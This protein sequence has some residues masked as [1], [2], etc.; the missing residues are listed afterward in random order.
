MTDLKKYQFKLPDTGVPATGALPGWG[1]RTS[2]A[3][4]HATVAPVSSELP[5]DAAGCLAKGNT[6]LQGGR[7]EDALRAY[8]RAIAL[9]PDYLEPH[10]NR[11]NVLLRL[12]RLPEA[13]AAFERA[14]A[15][16]P[17]LAIAHYNR[18]TILGT[19]GRADEALAG[20][21]RT[22][23]LDSTMVQAR[24][25]LGTLYLQKGDAEQALACLDQVIAQAP[26]VVQAHLARGNA[27]VKMKKLEQAGLSFDR[28]LALQPR[29]PEALS[30][31]GN[32]RLQAKQYAAALADLE[33]SVRL[34]PNYAQTH[35]LLGVLAR[36]TKRPEEA[37]VRFQK[38]YDLAPEKPGAL[39]DL[40][41]A[42]A[43][44]CD[45]HWLPEG[46]ARM[47]TAIQTG[48]KG[49][50][51]FS[52][53]ALSD[54]PAL[55][56][57]CA[58]QFA[59]VEH[60]AGSTLGSAVR[61]AGSSK[62][63]VGYYSADFHEHATAYLMAQLF[64]QHDRSQFEWFA[65]SYGPNTQDPMRQRLRKAFTQFL[66]VSGSSDLE[67]AALS[68]ELG[69]DVAV[70]L[71]GFTRDERM[72]IFANRCAPVQVSYLGY[73]GT[74]GADYMDY[75]IADPH[76]L[77]ASLHPYFTEKVVTLP[78]SYQV[79]DAS[80]RIAD[81]VFTREEVGLPE[82]GFVFCCFNNNYK[83]LPAVF[84]CWMRVLLAV[85][86]SVLWL[87]ADNDAAVR[88]LQ[89]EAAA[90]GVDPKRLVFAP[91]MPL[92]D[93]LARHALADLF[94]DTLPC[95]AHTTTSDALWAGL[96]VLTQTGSA[97]A[98]RV[99][100]SLLNAVGLPE[101]VTT[102]Q[103][104]Y[105][106]RAIELARDATQLRGLRDRLAANRLSSPLFNAKL[107]ARHIEAAY[108]AMDERSLQG[109]PPKAMEI[110]A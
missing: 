40:V 92:A 31:R 4:M 9:Q 62:I 71:K 19:T 95:N 93:H 81:R 66:D 38:A 64:E 37:L 47:E 29:Y 18:A 96:P 44:T 78:H 55:Q 30:N 13:L 91:R 76:V 46:M 60:P 27:L 5:A 98:G 17:E 65:F 43:A 54:S 89:R 7:I 16:S 45:W 75:V 2:A 51:P 22:L 68:R 56:L 90:R 106:A 32:V 103:A 23:A 80:R 33:A 77:P 87:L 49:I 12:Q 8:D 10:F 61:R 52:L 41:S 59:A 83:I 67:V 28:A 6:W 58:R 63:R 50:A 82:E 69:I 99:S 35:Q 85:E 107:F 72:G 100:T 14:I 105:A 109:L 26:N 36:E 48:Q 20:Y 84:A 104:E 102:T 88:N 39:T 74:T 57:E 86:G 70:D 42:M 73:P 11:G 110:R 1:N 101:L 34:N 24:F 94:L 25:N 3:A 97:F 15:L 53:L 21:Q 79:N 108:I